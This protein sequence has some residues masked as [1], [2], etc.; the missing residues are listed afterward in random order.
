ME[1]ELIADA[2]VAAFWLLASSAQNLFAS[3]LSSISLANARN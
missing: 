3:F 1:S 2:A